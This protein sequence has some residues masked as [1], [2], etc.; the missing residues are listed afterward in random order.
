MDS[1]VPLPQSGGISTKVV[2]EEEEEEEDYQEVWW[3]EV[4]AALLPEQ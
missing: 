3:K 2:G 1:G 4:E